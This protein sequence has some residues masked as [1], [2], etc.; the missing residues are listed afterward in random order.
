MVP[1]A[2]EFGW[3]RSLVAGA[4]TLT[5]MKS[6]ALAFV[7]GWLIDRYGPRRVLCVAMGLYALSI[8][9]FGMVPPSVPLFYI[10]FGITCALGAAL[11][12]TTFGKA[13]AGW[14]DGRRGTAMGLTAGIGTGLGSIGF[15]VMAGVLLT[16]FGWRAAFYG[17]AA[18][19]GLIAFPI[20]VL[21]FRS[22]PD[23]EKTLPSR[24]TVAGSEADF[25]LMEAMRTRQ[26][27][28]LA[29]SIGLCAGCMTAMFTQAVPVVQEQGF[30]LA[31][32]VAVVTVLAGVCSAWQPIMGYLLDRFGQ[33]FI[34]IPFYF[35]GTLGLWLI[36]HSS[37]MTVMLLAGGMMGLSLGAEYS[38]LPLLLSRYF[39]IRYFGT[40]AS[41]VYAGVAVL[42]GLVPAGMNALF[43]RMGNYHWALYAMEAAMLVATML[44]MLLPKRMDLLPKSSS[45]SGAVGQN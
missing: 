7:I 13:L 3:S 15:P 17:S 12:A 39:G 18:V 28:L 45:R 23:P 27:W 10:G 33:P 44:M 34:V 42:I 35:L 6:L 32:A 24:A 41:V 1:I 16:E 38:A 11:T 25:S 5:I 30:T 26:F 19:V 31:Q 29:A 4:M 43:D 8:L 14:F 2:E 36:H 37:S 40:I 9:A 20:V 22:P 21:L